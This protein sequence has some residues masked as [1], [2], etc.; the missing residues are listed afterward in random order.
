MTLYFFE[1]Q[2]SERF[3]S[4]AHLL[5]IVQIVDGYHALRDEKVQLRIRFDQHQLCSK[6]IISFEAAC[7]LF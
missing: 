3:V 5:G 2:N 6:T 4:Q 7:L 1:V